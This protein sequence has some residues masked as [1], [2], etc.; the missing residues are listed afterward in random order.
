MGWHLGMGKNQIVDCFYSPDG[1][2]ANFVW[3]LDNFV[4]NSP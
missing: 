1:M 3:R 2:L 4:F